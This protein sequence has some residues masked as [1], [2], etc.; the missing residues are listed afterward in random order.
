MVTRPPRKMGLVKRRL[1]CIQTSLQATVQQ[2]TLPPEQRPLLV[3]V[4]TPQEFSQG[5]IPGALNI[6]VD[7]LRRRLGEFPRDRQIAVYCQ[8]GQRGY[9]ATRILQQAG[10]SAANIGGGYKT[11]RLWYPQA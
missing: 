2:L 5:H 11:Y 1:F 6:P 7:E 8:V 3:D 9:L 4:R 10:F